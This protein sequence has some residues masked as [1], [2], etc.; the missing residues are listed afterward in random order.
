MREETHKN[1]I[2]EKSWRFH[3]FYLYER[4]KSKDFDFSQSTEV[5]Q[6]SSGNRLQTPILIGCKFLM[7]LTSTKQHLATPFQSLAVISWASNYIPGFKTWSNYFHSFLWSHGTRPKKKATHTTKKG[8]VCHATDWA[9]LTVRAWRC[10]TFTRESA[11]SSALSRFTVLFG[12][13]RS[14]TNL[15][16]S[17]GITG[18]QNVLGTICRI[19]RANQLLLVNA[20]TCWWASFECVNLA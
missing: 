10:P 14:G 17:S 18:W 9:F 19:H 3:I 8:P 13:G 7:I 16:W 2:D 15:L 1:G 5:N 12:K 4:L 6:K 11:L 20:H